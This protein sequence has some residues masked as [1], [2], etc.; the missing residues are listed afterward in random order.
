M[1]R[2]YIPLCV[3]FK[4]LGRVKKVSRRF[5][6]LFTYSV[7]VLKSVFGALIEITQSFYDLFFYFLL[8]YFAL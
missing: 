1:S 4:D 7:F 6:Y 8:V 5:M 3:H 2:V